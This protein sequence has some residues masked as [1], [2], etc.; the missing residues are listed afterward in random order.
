MNWIIVLLLNNRFKF[1]KLMKDL[2][3]IWNVDIK[4]DILVEFLIFD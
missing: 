2:L 1:D 3:W 4:K